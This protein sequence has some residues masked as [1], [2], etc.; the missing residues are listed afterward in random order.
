MFV[1]C[2][3][4]SPSSARVVRRGRNR[5][6]VKKMENE[7]HLQE[8]LYVRSLKSSCHEKAGCLLA[9]EPDDRPR[10]DCGERNPCPVMIALDRWRRVRG[11]I[12]FYV[13]GFAASAILAYW[14]NEALRIVLAVMTSV[15]VLLAYLQLKQLAL[16]KSIDDSLRHTHE[17][18]L[19]TESCP[20]PATRIEQSNNLA[21]D[22]LPPPPD[23]TTASNPPF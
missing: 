9:A 4:P 21:L 6:K 13:F 23:D 16:L 20:P 18:P 11:S 12:L 15:I 14:G 5:K 22:Q 7:R 1:W 17:K 10:L 2:K 19:L 3:R 8:S